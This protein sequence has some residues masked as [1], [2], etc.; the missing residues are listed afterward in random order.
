VTVTVWPAT[1]SVPVRGL[2]V[3]FAATLKL[4]EPVPDMPPLVTVIQPT[5]LVAVHAQ[6]LPVVTAILLLR[7]VDGAETLVGDALKV[8]LPAA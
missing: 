8:Q 1:V 5:E 6:E 4:T 3:G 2:V 7:P